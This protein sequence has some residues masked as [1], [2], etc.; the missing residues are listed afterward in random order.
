MTRLVMRAWVPLVM[1]VA[2][3]ALTSLAEVLPPRSYAVDFTG[4][5]G[6]L[7]VVRRGV[8]TPV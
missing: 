2:V 4:Q 3:A 5:A 6:A 1:A 7:K 8:L